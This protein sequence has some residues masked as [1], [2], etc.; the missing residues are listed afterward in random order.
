LQHLLIDIIMA[1]AI[2]MVH[3]QSPAPVD[4]T[5]IEEP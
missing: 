4:T 1:A 2:A 3:P 5:V